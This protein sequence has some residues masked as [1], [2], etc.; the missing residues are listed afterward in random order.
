MSPNRIERQRR[1]WEEVADFNPEWGVLTDSTAKQ[2]GW[3]L[4]PFLASGE[5][6]IAETMKVADRL[7][8]PS[9]RGAALDFG[10]GVGRLATSLSTR[11]ERYTGVDISEGMLQRARELNAANRNC[12]FALN[13]REDLGAF[14]DASY[15][16]IFSF[17]VLQHMSDP[18]MIHRYLVEFARVLRPGG[19]IAVQLVTHVPLIYR[20]RV[21]RRLYRLARAVGVSVDKAHL[22]GLQSMAITAV[23]V[24][25]VLGLFERTGC[26]VREHATDTA[27]QGVLSTTFYVTKG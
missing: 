16:A 15:D 26:S 13:D 11:F 1:D 21:R 27:Q 19:L 6:Q 2:E 12:E 20:L 3:D 22:S 25:D 17:L 24:D 18:E 5:F 14:D 4:D 23:G 10:C 9:G 7:G 8:L